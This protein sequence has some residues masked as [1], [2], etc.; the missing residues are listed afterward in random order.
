[1]QQLFITLAF[2]KRQFFRRKFSKIGKKCFYN[3][4]PGSRRKKCSAPVFAS[5][6]SS[7]IEPIKRCP[8]QQQ[9]P[10]QIASNLHFLQQTNYSRRAT[11]YESFRS[12][13]SGGSAFFVRMCVFCP[14]VRFL[15]GCF[16]PN[17]SFCRNVRF[18]PNVLFLSEYKQI[19]N[20]PL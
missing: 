17:M 5:R 7:K 6:T 10:T 16:C 2:L 3:I 11:F 12:T 18:C 15:S 4:D 1:M 14:N 13:D 19:C 8:Q 9:Q 20:S